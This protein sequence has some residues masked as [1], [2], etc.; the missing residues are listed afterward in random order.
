MT[1]Q[2]KLELGGRLRAKVTEQK[3]A[4]VS[5]P[6][7]SSKGVKLTV[8]G[9]MSKKADGFVIEYAL[10]KSARNWSRFSAGDL[11]VTKCYRFNQAGN[12]T[13]A[14]ELNP[15]GVANVKPGRVLVSSFAKRGFTADIMLRESGGR[16][17]PH[18][19][20]GGGRSDNGGSRG[21]RPMKSSGYYLPLPCGTTAR[22]TQ[23]NNGGFS[24]NNTKNQY[25][26]DFGIGTGKPLMAMRA[27]TVHAVY[28]GTRPGDP[29][30][31][32]GDKSC[33]SKANYVVLSHDDGS[34]SIY[35]HLSR[36]DVRKGVRVRQGQQVGLSGSTGQSTGPH[37]HIMRQKACSGLATK[38][39]SLPL[40]FEDVPGGVPKKND[41]VT[42][43]NCPAGQRT[44]GASAGGRNTGDGNRASGGRANNGRR[45]S[46]NTRRG[47][48]KNR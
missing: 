25:A 15:A 41:R 24:H 28:D 1:P 27:G 2:R 39:H 47:R 43:G 33:Y 40:K 18:T 20:A 34:R 12:P 45:K 5:V 10:K 22:I 23:G 9:G 6:Y 26:F 14:F 19:S 37:V 46:N 44:S 42:S 38:C 7:F 32:G 16:G 29:C 4:F 17:K 21:Q 13:T 30:Y 11:V 31:N 3:F 35:K 48:R 8:R 36:V